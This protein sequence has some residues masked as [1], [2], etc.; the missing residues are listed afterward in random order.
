VHPICLDATAALLEKDTTLERQGSEAE[1]L[2]HALQVQKTVDSVMFRRHP[3]SGEATAEWFPVP[4]VDEH[5]GL[6]SE[7]LHM[8]EAAFSERTL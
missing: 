5:T 2:E 8:P 7:V 4:A 3:W 1:E 6:S